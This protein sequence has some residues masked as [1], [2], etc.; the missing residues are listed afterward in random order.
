MIFPFGAGILS[1]YALTTY[2]SGNEKGAQ[3]PVKSLILKIKSYRVHIHH[4]M[5]QLALMLT[6]IAL[7][8]KQM[9]IMPGWLFESIIGLNAGAIIQGL[10]YKDWKHIIWKEDVSDSS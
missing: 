7:H 9:L 2:T 4:W 10:R 1:G 6:L 5:H 3:G 8:M